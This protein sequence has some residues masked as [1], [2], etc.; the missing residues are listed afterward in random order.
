MKNLPLPIF[1]RLFAVLA[2]FPSFL[3]AQWQSLGGP[4][5][6]PPECMAETPDGTLYAGNF[7]GAYESFDQG[8]TWARIVELPSEAYAVKTFGNR[9]GFIVS[10]GG[11]DWDELYILRPEIAKW[12]LVPLPMSTNYSTAD[13][14]L[15]EDHIIVMID[16]FG[17]EKR[18]EDIHWKPLKA[19]N[20]L[21]K[22]FSVLYQNGNQVWA[23]GSNAVAKSTNGGADWVVWYDLSMPT[24]DLVSAWG[25]GDTL[26]ISRYAGA[27]G[28]KTHRTLNKGQTWS[29]PFA[30]QGNYVES[31]IRFQGKFYGLTFYGL[32]TSSNNG[33]SWASV[34]VIRSQFKRVFSSSTALFIA[35]YNGGFYRN[36][37]PGVEGWI[38]VGEG[39]EG[40]Y[41]YDLAAN[42]NWLIG[43][44]GFSGVSR[45]DKQNN[46]WLPNAVVHEF[47]RIENVSVTPT[48]FFASPNYHESD[49]ALFFAPGN[50]SGWTDAKI[51]GAWGLVDFDL[52]E[53]ALNRC[54]A[55]ST[56]PF[57]GSERLVSNDGGSTFESASAYQ[58]RLRN[59]N[60][61]FYGILKDSLGLYS[62]ANTATWVSVGKAGLDPQDR[63]LDFFSL[64]Q[65]IFLKARPQNNPDSMRLYYSEDLGASWQHVSTVRYYDFDYSTFIGNENIVME[66]GR[67][68]Y[69]SDQGR[70]WHNMPKD[71]L[72]IRYITGEDREQ[73]YGIPYG[74]YG[75]VHRI[76]YEDMHFQPLVVTTF[77][78]LNNNGT[79]D[80]NESA[81]PNVLIRNRKTSDL[82]T[83]NATGEARFTLNLAPGAL[84]TLE[85]GNPGS[86]VLQPVDQKVIVQQGD[87]AIFVPLR[88]VQKQDLGVYMAQ[89]RMF[90]KD[91]LCSFVVFS[92]NT[93]SQLSLAGAKMRLKLPIGPIPEFSRTPDFITGDTLTWIIPALAEGENFMVA[94][95]FVSPDDWDIDK[96]LSYTAWLEGTAGDADGKNNEAS[97]LVLAS[98]FPFPQYGWTTANKEE[99]AIGDLQAGASGL[100]YGVTMGDLSQISFIDI[101]KM[102]AFLRGN[103]LDL[104]RS[105]FL[106]SSCPTALT[107][108]VYDLPAWITTGF[109]NNTALFPEDSN[110]VFIVFA[111][112]LETE[113]LEV[114]DLLGL[115][116]A[117]RFNDSFVLSSSPNNA[118]IR[119]TDGVNASEP[120]V[121][122]ILP[123]LSIIPNPSRGGFTLLPEGFEEVS[124]QVDILD[125]LGRVQQSSRWTRGEP[126]RCTLPAGE[127]FVRLIG[128]E[129]VLSAKLTLVD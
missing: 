64:G 85:I 27:A 7:T 121:R 98:A 63:M 65:H 14:A 87:S 125:A 13:F 69:S 120:T 28:P 91:S 12:K 49:S 1:F 40:L 75:L 70:T 129:A 66:N 19:M 38:R 53:C 46:T 82:L 88:R 108:G 77:E 8:K 105:K 111:A 23:L 42:E 93:G 73:I 102:S 78:D 10:R 33:T 17:W 83:T 71:K 128:S 76:R 80:A 37:L 56:D 26:I 101:L 52:V 3:S 115:S 74:N 68:R 44:A 94:G 31:V 35:E 123:K 106:A 58:P 95:R 127:Y 92:R 11:G 51:T 72:G 113:G 109:E 18:Y 124:G 20:N 54:V 96:R 84:D 6:G 116:S 5:G 9:V 126:L 86:Q 47:L 60:G 118:I 61:V 67:Y 57:T 122:Q 62:S 22:Y 59:V 55:Y 48:R 100:V 119:I 15:F 34:P 112:E 110:L 103:G 50:A 21:G 2:F 97:L 25:N 90:Q 30:F 41:T 89:T 16:G 114:G 4:Y 43:A 99:V 79:K 36:D 107:A 104:T 32:V 39:M 117:L 29:Q 24:G 45:Y 81:V